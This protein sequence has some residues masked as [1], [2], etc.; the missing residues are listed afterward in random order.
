MNKSKTFLALFFMFFMSI[1]FAQTEKE[2]KKM[3]EKMCKELKKISH[4]D[5]SIRIQH[6]FDNNLPFYLASS[7]YNEENTDSIINHLLFNFYQE[8]D[9]YAILY[10]KVYHDDP[11]WELLIEKPIIKI[12]EEEVNQFKQHNQFY[13]F[14][15]SSGNKTFIT[16]K[17]GYWLEKMEDDT[18]SKCKIKW[19]KKGFTL[20]F[21]ESNNVYKKEHNKKGDKYYYTLLEKKESYYWVQLKNKGRKTS[22]KYKLY[23]L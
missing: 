13:Y 9:E 4:L 11:S 20:I 10:S 7:M 12:S 16:L 22:A 8:C 21:E 17:D 1:S 14:E 23:K 19:R 6:V 3:V 5:D 15:P 2:E 18:F